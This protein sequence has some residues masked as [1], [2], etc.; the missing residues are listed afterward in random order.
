MKKIL[1]GFVLIVVFASCVKTNTI[2]D[3]SVDTLYL[4][5]LPHITIDTFNRSTIIVDT[6]VVHT[7]DT[8]K[9][10]AHDTLFITKTIYDTLFKSFLDTVYLTKQIHDTVVTVRTI[11]KND[12]IINQQI[13]Q[14]HD[15]VVKSVVVQVHDTV[16][17]TV[18]LHDTLDIIQKIFINDTVVKVNTI[19]I[20]DT[21]LRFQQ[22]D[23]Y[24]TPAVD[25][26]TML[27][28][29]DTAN[30][31]SNLY[32]RHVTLNYITFTSVVPSP[33][34]S[35]QTFTTVPRYDTTREQYTNRLINA[36]IVVAPKMLCTITFNYD[37]KNGCTF[38]LY[39]Y[40]PFEQNPYT[41]YKATSPGKI[42]SAT[43]A[44]TKMEPLFL[45]DIQYIIVSTNF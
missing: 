10:V 31:G 15:T 2:H 1:F 39:S 43:G 28:M 34:G 33:D 9:Q 44:T 14:V 13:V 5:S 11:I 20:R 41:T 21:V 40:S 6:V 29:L 26:V 16:N 23:G 32:N 36:W 22:L 24:P 8:V 18:F 17:K 3:L 27:Y 12:T 4:P 19:T 30:D 35:Y 7:T 25:S 42:A 37:W 45:D 38:L